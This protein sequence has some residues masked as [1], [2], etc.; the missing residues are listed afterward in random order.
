MFIQV[1]PIPY[2]LCTSHYVIYYISNRY[3]W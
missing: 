3:I 2:T 1:N